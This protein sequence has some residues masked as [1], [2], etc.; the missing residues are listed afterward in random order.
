MAKAVKQKEPIQEGITNPISIPD[1]PAQME[2]TEKMSEVSVENIDVSESEVE[3]L[4]RILNIQH[5]GGFGRHLD[6]IINE[7]IKSIQ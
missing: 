4:K 3:F 5:T 6:T 7:R 1:I 2:E